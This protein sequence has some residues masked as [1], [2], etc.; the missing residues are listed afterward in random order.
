MSLR[1]SRTARLVA[2]LFVAACC[3]SSA[4]AYT[5]SLNNTA[6]TAGGFGSAGISGYTPSSPAFTLNLTG[7][8]QSITQ[9]S[10]SLSPA[11]AKSVSVKLSNGA[12]WYTC[13]AGATAT[14]TTT[15]PQAVVSSGLTQ[16]AVVAAQ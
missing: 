11:T 14:C 12:S 16:L 6:G 13:T 1:R 3:A 7:N 2:T 9:L 8:P 15:S 4:Y 10:M 5:A